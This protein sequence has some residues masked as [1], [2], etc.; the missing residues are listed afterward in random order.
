[1]KCEPHAGHLDFATRL[2][3]QLSGNGS[4]VWSPWS[5]AEALSLLAVGA[6]GSTLDE[7]AGVLGGDVDGH[8]AA[9]MGVAAGEPALRTA[10][11]LWVRAGA[12]VL[13]EFAAALARRPSASVEIGDFAADPDGVRRAVNAHVRDATGGGIPE[14]LAPRSV[15]ADTRAVLLSALLVR[16][17]WPVPFAPARTTRL[18]FREPG[19]AERMVPMMRRRGLLSYAEAR[20]WRMVSLDGGSGCTLDVL[21]AED[22]AAAAP[23]AADLV[24]L[25]RS[26][27]PA[28]IALALPRFEVA[29]RAE[30]N[31]PLRALGVRT[32]FSTS[33]D[34]SG[35]VDEPLLVD[36]VVHQARLRV[37]EHGAEGSA[38]TAVL[39]APGSALPP[40]P[41]LEFTVDRPFRF[42]LR[43]DG[44]IL[45][46]GHVTSPIDPGESPPARAADG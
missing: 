9:L 37:D 4:H 38:A 21:L 41:P 45:F 19:A 2:D 35:I 46:L 18:P 32:A 7:L 5:V 1:M 31:V 28:D 24:A 3:A 17:R 25:Y 22:P 10:V 44:V 13:P 15:T 14:L 20:G 40:P 34:L 36:R 12:R 26:A 30:L 29:A 33:A 27:R 16:L 43:K 42:A 23:R 11:S 6:R 39:A 8:A